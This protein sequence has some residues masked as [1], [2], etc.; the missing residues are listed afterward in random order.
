MVPGSKFSEA[1]FAL[2]RPTRTERGADGS[3]RSRADPGEGPPS[4]RVKL[5]CVSRMS[6]FMMMGCTPA[7]SK[8]RL[9][10]RGQFG[11]EGGRLVT[12]F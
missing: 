1:V 8:G 9:L 4:T 5:P 2:S 12:Y 11:A 6:M 7:S 10:R 3:L